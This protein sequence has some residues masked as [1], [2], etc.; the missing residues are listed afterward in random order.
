MKNLTITIDEKLARWVR[1]SAAEQDMSMSR[2]IADLLHRRMMNAQ[3]YESAMKSNLSREPMPI[4]S[5]KP[6]PK[7]SEIHDR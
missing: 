1:V 6:Y 2:Y 4:S 3:E 5:R 7:R